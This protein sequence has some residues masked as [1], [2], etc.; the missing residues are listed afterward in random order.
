MRAYDVSSINNGRALA[1][2]GTFQDG[3]HPHRLPDTCVGSQA[4]IL[5]NER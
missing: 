4:D 2:L 5:T 3:A 1:I